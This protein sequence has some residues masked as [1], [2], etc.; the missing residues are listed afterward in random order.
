MYFIGIDV[1]KNK[2]D[3]NVL[4]PSM[5]TVEEKVLKNRV[6]KLTSYLSKLAR[7]LEGKELMICC[8]NTGIYTVPLEQ[9]CQKLGLKLWVEHA[10]KIKRASPDYRG[11]SDRRDAL[12]IA[13][14]ACRYQDLARLHVPMSQSNKKAKTLLNVRED[15]I[16]QRQGVKT[17]LSEAKS[18]DP[19]RYQV[20]A[21][22]FTPVI[23]CLN[24]QIKKV[25]KELEQLLASD[26]AVK[27]NMELLMSISGV[28]KQTA[29][30]FIVATENFTRFDGPEHMACYAGVAPFPNQSGNIARPDRVSKHANKKLKRLL[31]LAAM[32][33]IRSK[34][35]LK[36]YYKRKVAEGK[37]KMLVLNNVRNKLIKRMFAVIQRQTPY[38][39]SQTEFLSKQ[40]NV[41]L[42]T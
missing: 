37:N 22:T 9:T 32:A 5:E 26:P 7:K 6:A 19:E 42:V 30:N 16:T 36:D 35:D 4:S 25:E 29:M 41:C 38:I 23:N 18:H 8:E 39:K 24:R 20:L 1:S 40:E 13:T 14:Y 33:A 3:V 31:H 27:R 17:R 11:K 21:S 28:G 2:V 10:L 12:R 15:L 34:S